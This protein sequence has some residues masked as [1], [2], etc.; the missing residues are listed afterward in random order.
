MPAGRCAYDGTCA[1][2]PRLE[3]LR[4]LPEPAGA[5]KAARRKG[6]Y[7]FGAAAKSSYR[8]SK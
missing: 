5:I 8:T 1:P 4:A 3:S 2:Q 7:G 6:A